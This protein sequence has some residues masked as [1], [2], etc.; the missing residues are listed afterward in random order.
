MPEKVV[1]PRIVA[2]RGESY[3]LPENTLP[4][5]ELGWRN[6]PFAVET[7]VHISRDNRL[8]VSHDGH[9]RRTAGLDRAIAEMTASEIA[10]VDVGS[11]KDPAFA[12]LRPPLLE[13]V[14]AAMPADGRLYMEIKVDDPRFVPLFRAAMEAAGIRQEQITAISFHPEAL[15]RLNREYPG[16]VTSLLLG[17][18]ET[19]TIPNLIHDLRA[20]GCAGVSPHFQRPWIAPEPIKELHAAGFGIHVWTVDDP[21]EARRCAQA[22]VDSITSNRA[23]WLRRNWE[24]Q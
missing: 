9:F 16:F 17:G 1:M 4:A 18:D 12:D 3:L 8:I 19:Y 11:W 23:A 15:A 20:I 10:A 7:D 24:A 21:A 13:E 14:L 5:L 6:K 2:H 22:G